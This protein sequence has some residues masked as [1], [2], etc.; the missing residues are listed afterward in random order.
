MWLYPH[1][2]TPNSALR[3]LHNLHACPVTHAIGAR[4]PNLVPNPLYPSPLGK[5]KG[6]IVNHASSVLAWSGE[7]Y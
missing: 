3:N 1:S 6:G 2:K 5:I 4:L 7:Q